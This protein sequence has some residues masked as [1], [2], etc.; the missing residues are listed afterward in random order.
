MT[1]VELISLRDEAERLIRN[2]A[3]MQRNTIEKQL[4]RISSYVGGGPA[5]KGRRRSS[6]AKRSKVVPK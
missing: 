2:R 4:A 6:S 3:L 1:L 5:R